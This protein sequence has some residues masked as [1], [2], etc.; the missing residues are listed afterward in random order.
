MPAANTMRVQMRLMTNGLQNLLD[1]RLRHRLRAD[2][3]SWQVFS[4]DNIAVMATPS[5]DFYV[6]ELRYERQDGL[7]NPVEV[8]RP[9]LRSGAM[10]VVISRNVGQMDGVDCR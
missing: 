7:K 8:S 4:P 2:R 10:E 1:L 6:K 3:S 9:Q 5:Q